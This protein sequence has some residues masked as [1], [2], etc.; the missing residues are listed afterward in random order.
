MSL[1]LECP[2]CHSS[3]IRTNIELHVEMCLQNQESSSSVQSKPAKEL[4][5]TKEESTP[6]VEANSNSTLQ[7]KESN[8]VDERKPLADRLRPTSFDQ[9]KGN[10]ELFGEGCTVRTL[11]ERDPPPSFILVG[12]PGCGK[13]T[14]AYIISK[15]TKCPFKTLS[16]CTCGIDDVNT[17]LGECEKTYSSAKIPTILF[18]DEIHRFNK[19]QQD[20]FLPFVESGKLVMI[21][22]TTENPSFSITAALLSRCRVFP[23]QLLKTDEIQSLLKHALET[24]TQLKN[25]G[26]S[27]CLCVTRRLLLRTRFWK[28]L[29]PEVM[30][31]LEAL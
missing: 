13:T 2:I 8:S 26:V 31:M 10:R 4:N 9:L 28:R 19:K 5:S 27:R 7:P 22:A 12:P 29:V 23:L 16:C 18:L 17:V 14:V 30:E 11:L 24:D 1:F 20:V 3:I 15:R 6:I 21:G 25:Y